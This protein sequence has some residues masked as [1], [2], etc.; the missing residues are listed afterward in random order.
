MK[1]P[2]NIALFILYEQFLSSRAIKR[3]RKEIEEN[4]DGIIILDG[5]PKLFYVDRKLIQDP[6]QIHAPGDE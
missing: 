3:I 6:L 4:T 5:D 2:D 1:I